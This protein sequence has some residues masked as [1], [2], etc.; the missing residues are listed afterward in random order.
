MNYY[1]PLYKGLR[2]VKGEGT[3]NIQYTT[4]KC[5]LGRGKGDKGHG[6][7]GGG[8][9]L[10]LNSQERGTM[11]KAVHIMGMPLHCVLLVA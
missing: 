8:Y 11:K 9:A 6:R 1:H 3:E 2:K 5:L 4:S 7:G 10:F